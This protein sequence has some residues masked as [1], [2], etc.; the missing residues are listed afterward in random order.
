[1]CVVLV[2]P[3]LL[4]RKVTSFLL[5]FPNTYQQPIR[6][7]FAHSHALLHICQHSFFLLSLASSLSLIVMLDLIQFQHPS[8]RHL[9]S[10][11]FFFLFLNHVLQLRVCFFFFCVQHNSCFSPCLCVMFALKILDFFNRGTS[12][13]FPFFFRVKNTEVSSLCA[14][15][16]L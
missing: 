12:V 4:H 16:Y 11:F 7:V 3:V 13:F 2:S 9:Y 15:F 6:R 10:C 8:A 14:S 5:I 1:M